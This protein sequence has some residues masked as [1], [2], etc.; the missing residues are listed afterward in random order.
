MKPTLPSTPSNP[1]SSI[2]Y[3]F[4]PTGLQ[5]APVPNPILPITSSLSLL[6]FPRAL[7]LPTPIFLSLDLI[8]VHPKAAR[9][10]SSACRW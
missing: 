7:L 10:M 6:P 5:S 4:L 9:L 2:G 3:S 1:N 8:S